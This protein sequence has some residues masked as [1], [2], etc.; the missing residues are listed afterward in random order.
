MELP[1]Q[2]STQRFEAPITGME[3]SVSTP[4]GLFE[5]DTGDRY[6]VTNAGIGKIA[7]ILRH[8]T[9]SCFSWTALTPLAIA[10]GVW[11]GDGEIELTHLATPEG[12]E[13]GTL[14]FVDRGWIYLRCRQECSGL[15]WIM[16]AT[17]NETAEDKDYDGW[18]IL[19]WGRTFFEWTP[20]QA[21]FPLVLPFNLLRSMGG[22]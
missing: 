17:T 14:S 20:P 10:T 12:E 16:I 13:L 19:K 2:E 6:L 1:D 22:M 3:L 8:R 11:L 7:I 4:C 15:A 5:T 21:S 18:R 9:A